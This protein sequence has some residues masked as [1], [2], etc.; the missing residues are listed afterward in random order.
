[1]LV[2]VQPDV[3]AARLT[4]LT[5]DHVESGNSLSSPIR[6][7]FL[8]PVKAQ[9]KDKAASKKAKTRVVEISDG[10]ENH[11]DVDKEEGSAEN[12]DIDD[13]S[14]SKRKRASA[15]SSASKSRPK[16]ENP[17]D[18]SQGPNGSRAG[19]RGSTGRE[20]KAQRK[21]VE[22]SEEEVDLTAPMDGSEYWDDLDVEDYPVY[23]E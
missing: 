23:G 18:E 15:G 19:A 1:M 13:S 20:R 10:E 14:T 9:R 2:Y 3:R 8:V 12:G 11:A 21:E 4:R 7:T 16:K 17:E 5:R 6:C 22:L